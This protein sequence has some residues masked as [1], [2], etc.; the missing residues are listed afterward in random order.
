MSVVNTQC[1]RIYLVS[2]CG[3]KRRSKTWR[4]KRRND[5]SFFQHGAVCQD[6]QNSRQRTNMNSSVKN[7][8]VIVTE[9]HTHT[10]IHTQNALQSVNHEDSN[11]LG[12]Y[13]AITGPSHRFQESERSHCSRG[14]I[15]SKRASMI[16]VRGRSVPFGHSII[17]LPGLQGGRTD[18]HTNQNTHYT[19]ILAHT[20]S[21]SPPVYKDNI[22]C[23]LFNMF[24]CWAMLGHFLYSVQ[25]YL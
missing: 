12:W 13:S 3:G 2:W 9:T 15:L 6:L 16:H 10:G 18:A 24:Y 19:H 20:V 14:F 8:C 21:W 23:C 7:L 5:Y 4:V 1:C 25:I 22:R 17:M 11:T